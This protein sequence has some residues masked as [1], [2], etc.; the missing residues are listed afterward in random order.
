LRS[1]LGVDRS[2]LRNLLQG[3]LEG[4]R[5]PAGELSLALIGDRTM[6]RINRDSRGIDRTTDVLSFSYVDEPHSG[7]VLGEVFVSPAVA[8]EQAREAGCG[9]DEEIARLSVHGTLHVLGWDHGTA[10]TRRRMLR[11]QESYVKRLFLEPVS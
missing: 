2:R 10:D 9:L 3:T 1:T 5:A 8:G 6:R 11:R 7:G 4:E